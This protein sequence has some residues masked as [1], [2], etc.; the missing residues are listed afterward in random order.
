MN[1]RKRQ[2]TKESKAK[3]NDTE[4]EPHSYETKDTGTALATTEDKARN[5]ALRWWATNPI[6][7]YPCSDE[8]EYTEW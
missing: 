5:D 4:D 7:F 3:E 6:D 2:A 1:Q 8:V